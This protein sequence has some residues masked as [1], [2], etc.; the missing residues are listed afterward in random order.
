VKSRSITST[1]VLLACINGTW[2]RAIAQTSVKTYEAQEVQRTQELRRKKEALE[3][4]A[5]Q[6]QQNLK[7]QK[8]AYE[9]QQLAAQRALEVK[10]D[11]YR[12]FQNRATRFI[13]S[14]IKICN[15]KL[16]IFDGQKI[17]EIQNKNR[18]ILDKDYDVYTSINFESISELDKL[19]KGISEKA[20][21]KLFVKVQDYSNLYERHNYTG[22]RWTEWYP[23]RN[24]G[25]ENDARYIDFGNVVITR[26]NDRSFEFYSSGRYPFK[27]TETSSGYMIDRDN[28]TGKYFTSFVQNGFLEVKGQRLDD[29][30]QM[31][32]LTNNIDLASMFSWA[33]LHRSQQ[34]NLQPTPIN[35]QSWVS[36]NDYPSAA[37]ANEEQGTVEFELAISASG[38]VENCVIIQSSG[39][40]S[41]DLA[42][43]NLVKRRARFNPATDSLGRPI[44]A[45]SKDRLT[46]RL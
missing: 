23:S 2:E 8:A 1:I 34:P 43:C 19:N 7:R 28:L 33:D 16:Q 3:R 46:W 42:T 4:S 37:R 20:V 13:Y 10:K 29:V 9:V 40:T 17:Y 18:P 41:L 26:S 36:M 12:P 22:R 44:S 32:C 6:R 24:D 21:I 27:A 25:Y 31:N 14:A 38:A 35:R 15:D 39:S 11:Q 5:L 30:D 45:K